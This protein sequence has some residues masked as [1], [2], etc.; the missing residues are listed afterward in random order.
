M[1]KF[2]IEMTTDDAKKILLAN[3]NLIEPKI[4]QE[5]VEKILSEF[6][7]FEEKNISLLEK[8][9]ELNKKNSELENLKKKLGHSK[10][11]GMTG[12]KIYNNWGAIKARCLN[13][14]SFAYK[15]YGGRGITIFDE[16]KNDFSS[17]YNYVSKLPHFGEEGYT[18]DRID[19]N[20]NY[21]PG[22]VRWATK[23]MQSNNRRNTIFVEYEGK[24]VTLTEAAKLSGIH[25]N[26]LH[27]R[28]HKGLRGEKLFEDVNLTQSEKRAKRKNYLNNR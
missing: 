24:K 4:L 18:L 23:K 11:H 22:N 6:S 9:F 28:Y 3:L 27:N 17:F 5:A 20:K 12:T 13:K 21:E 7:L 10:T 8:N 25:K 1:E 15:Y 16:W 2:K 26:T 19:A 14:N